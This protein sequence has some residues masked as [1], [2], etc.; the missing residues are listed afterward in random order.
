MLILTSVL[1]CSLCVLLICVFRLILPRL[2][3]IDKPTARKAHLNETPL[4]GGLAMYLSFMISLLVLFPYTAFISEIILAS[5]LLVIIGMF[6]DAYGSPPKT[7]L[8]VQ[9]V[10]VSYFS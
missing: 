2:G 7:R 6:D 5:F 8:V 3:L 1:V 9:L 10:A 4:V